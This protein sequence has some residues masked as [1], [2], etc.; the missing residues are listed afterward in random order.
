MCFANS[1]QHLGT[2]SKTVPLPRRQLFATGSS[3]LG[4]CAGR[5][6]SALAHRLLALTSVTGA[7]RTALAHLSTGNA[8]I[9]MAVATIGLYGHLARSVADGQ[10]ASD[11]VT[12]ACAEAAAAAFGV[13]QNVCGAGREA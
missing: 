8:Q 13:L 1:V 6:P 10:Q 9:Y 4:L 12:R 2:L 5:P 11:P 3:R 7:A